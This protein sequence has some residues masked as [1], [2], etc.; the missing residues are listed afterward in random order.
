MHVDT[1]LYSIL[2]IDVYSLYSTMCRYFS[3]FEALLLA[4][5]AR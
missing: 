2:Y 5:R 4:I 1:A 3:T